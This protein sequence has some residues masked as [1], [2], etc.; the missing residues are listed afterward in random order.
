LSVHNY[1]Q[2][3]R[4]DAK[5]FGQKERRIYVV[6]LFIAYK[7]ACM[8]MQPLPIMQGISGSVIRSSLDMKWV[9]T[10]IHISNGLPSM[11]NILFNVTVFATYSSSLY[12]CECI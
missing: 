8:E 1:T 4:D 6:G 12:P 2:A 7:F 10:H 11:L 5:G 3:Q 9:P